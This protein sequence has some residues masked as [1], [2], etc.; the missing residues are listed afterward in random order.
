MRFRHSAVIVIIALLTL[1]SLATVSIV[2]ARHPPTPVCGVCSLN[3]TA[4][5]GSAIT[6]NNS[7]LTIT[8]HENGSTTWRAQATLTAGK[9]ILAENESL[10]Q[11]VVTDNTRR[12]I[13][14]AKEVNSRIDGDTLIVDYSDSTTTES[15]FGAVVFMPLSP[16][17]PGLPFVM[18]GEGPRYLGTDRLTIQAPPGYEL[19]SDTPTTEEGQ[20]LVWTRGSERTHLDVTQDPVAIKKD[21]LLSGSRVWLA[22]TLS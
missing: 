11:E 3:Q 13:A 14:D 2:D 4:P 8:V 16:E 6:S 17:G 19:R 1:S 5:D 9:D 15:Y 18:G 12:S 7:T 21:A 20:K 10:R 22:R